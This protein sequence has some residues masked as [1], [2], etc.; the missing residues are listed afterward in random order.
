MH[1]DTVLVKRRV[2]FSVHNLLNWLTS[3]YSIIS[4][5]RTGLFISYMYECNLVYYALFS[6]FPSTKMAV[7][8]NLSFFQRPVRFPYS[9]Q[10]TDFRIIHNLQFTYTMVY[11]LYV[12]MS[13]CL[14]YLSIICLVFFYKNMVVSMIF[15]FCLIS[16]LPNPFACYMYLIHIAR[17][18]NSYDI[19]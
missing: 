14:W 13:S 10:P 6:S 11:Q 15:T 7:S 4:I 2:K 3:G 12:W 5:S 18:S 19:K 1:N 16:L 9:S 17:L 8:K